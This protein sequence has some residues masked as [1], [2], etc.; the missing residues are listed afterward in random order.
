MADEKDSRY[1]CDAW[2]F[3]GA[4]ARAPLP[5]RARILLNSHQIGGKADLARKI[6][7]RT[8]FTDCQSRTKSRPLHKKPAGRR[9][10][11]GPMGRSST[12]KWSRPVEFVI[13]FGAEHVRLVVERRR[14][15]WQWRRGRLSQR[16]GPKVHIQVLNAERPLCRERVFDA[17]AGGPSRLSVRISKRARENAGAGF[18]VGVLEAAKGHAAGA[19]QEPVAGR[20]ADARAHRTGP[21]LLGA[22]R[23]EIAKDVAAGESRGIRS[24]TPSKVALNAEPQ[25]T[26]LPV[27]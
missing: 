20:Q 26:Q 15:G 9:A 2:V 23:G 7:R 13:Q 11:C 25:G 19:V 22:E 12:G 6:A 1:Q 16:R 21:V 10:S 14:R 27:I 17:S 5:S 8:T 18:R 24:M 3:E 4:M